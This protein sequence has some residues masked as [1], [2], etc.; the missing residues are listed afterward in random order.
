MVSYENFFTSRFKQIQAINTALTVQSKDGKD[1][2]NLA[3]QKD[4]VCQILS[5]LW[6]IKAMTL[7]ADEAFKFVARDDKSAPGFYRQILAAQR[8]AQVGRDKIACYTNTYQ[9]LGG[10]G[11]FTQDIYSVDPDTMATHFAGQNM[12]CI[13]ALIL[14]PPD[15]HAIAGFGNNGVWTFFDPNFGQAA[16]LSPANLRDLFSLCK[17]Y[18]AKYTMH[19]FRVYKIQ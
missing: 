4:G 17:S 2:G 11:G 14:A 12:F 16:N 9:L 8:D 15:G 7:G 3:A 19:G 5:F 10:K 13:V 18:Y 1:T 6:L